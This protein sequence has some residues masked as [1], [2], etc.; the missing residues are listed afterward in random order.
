MDMTSPG[1]SVKPI[2][3]ISG[4]SPFCETFLDHVR[5]PRTQVIGEINKGWTVAKAL[6]GHER[7]M[8][9][10]IGKGF[11]GASTERGA[12]DLARDYLGER[13][14][15]IADAVVRDRLA[16]ARNGPALPRLDAGPLARH[17][18]GGPRAGPGDLDLQVLRHRAQ[19]AAP[20]AHGVD[21]RPA[22]A[23][24]GGRR[25]RRPRSSS[26]PASGCARAATRSRAAPRR[27][28]STSSP[29]ASWACR[30]E[31][32]HGDTEARRPSLRVSV[33]PG[34]VF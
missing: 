4:Y 33:P 32:H 34:E 7:T 9:A 30:T 10:D 1:V 17:R 13:D 14:G 19:Q 12:V 16:Q 18:Q 6:L 28:S 27:S 20:R 15:R 26:S 8:I 2:K 11:G 23:R 3:L 22:G 5:V 21:P 24:L 25:L 29:S 31:S